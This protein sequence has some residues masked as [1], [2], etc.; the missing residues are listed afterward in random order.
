MRDSQRKVV[1]LRGNKDKWYEQAIF[2]L[3]EGAA[4][5]EM[6]C[7][8]EAERIVSGGA[9]PVALPYVQPQAQM[10]TKK[11]GATA[12]PKKGKKLDGMLNV[13][14]LLTGV[15]LVALIAYHFL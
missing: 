11:D 12:P 3:R 1:M 9:M 4:Q 15:A 13:A 6:D 5:G 14:L 7:I 10:Q 8:K 2:I